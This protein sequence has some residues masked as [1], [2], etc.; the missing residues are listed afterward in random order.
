M[1][2]QYRH[3]NLSYSGRKGEMWWGTQCLYTTGANVIAGDLRGL[4]AQSQAITQTT[5]TVFVPADFTYEQRRAVGLILDDNAAT[6]GELHLAAGGYTTNL[7]VRGS[8]AVGQFLRLDTGGVSKA[9][10]SPG[11]CYSYALALEAHSGSSPSNIFA[12]SFP[13]RV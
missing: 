9:N 1:S 12:Y 13:W 10:P 3:A 7:K 6:G 2:Y 4:M 8:V 5:V 11:S